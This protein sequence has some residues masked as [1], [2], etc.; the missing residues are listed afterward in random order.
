MRKRSLSMAA[1]L[2][3]VPLMAASAWADPV[4]PSPTLT[5]GNI[6]FDNFTCSVVSGN[7]LTCGA[8]SVTPYT[9][10]SPPDAIPGDYG[11]R[12]QGAF[13]ASPTTEDVIITYDAHISGALFSD[14]EMYFNGTAV[15]SVSE[16][17]YNLAD[18][19][20]IGTLLVTNPPPV[21][22]DT[23]TLSENASDIYVVKDIGL[24]FSG[25]TP[26]TISLVDQN[27]SQVP[28]PAS[29]A[30]L[31]TALFGMGLFGRR[32]RRA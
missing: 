21:Y 18:N 25:S 29:L 4:S 28:E 12:F 19:H 1:A 24:D 26:G 27:F 3:A 22:T 8:I 20:V 13:N 32:R 16:Q 9:S 7:G 6:T 11:I 5:S 15:S 17:I 10:T 14:A 2:L 31:G 23:T 30:L